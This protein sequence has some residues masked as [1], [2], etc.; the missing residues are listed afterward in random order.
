MNF[1]FFWVHYISERRVHKANEK[2]H[3]LT[4][5]N[6]RYNNKNSITKTFMQEKKVRNEN[7]ICFS[8]FFDDSI[9]DGVLLLFILAFFFA[10]PFSTV[11]I[12]FTYSALTACTVAFAAITIYRLTCVCCIPWAIRLTTIDEKKNETNC[13]DSWCIHFWSNCWSCEKKKPV[14]FWSA[15]ICLCKSEVPQ[16]MAYL[17]YL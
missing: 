4:N 1:S 5:H 9:Q 12:L 14:G 8:P 15:L 10:F 16:A 13:D 17:R 3:N 2:I 7:Y 11:T 6:Y